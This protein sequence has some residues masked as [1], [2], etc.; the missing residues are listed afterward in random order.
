[1]GYRWILP[2]LALVALLGSSGRTE[3]QP[4]SYFTGNTGHIVISVLPL[5]AQ[6]RLDGVPIGTGHDLTARLLAVFPGP[7]VLEVSA[8][9]YVT[10]VVNFPGYHDWFTSVDVQLVPDRRP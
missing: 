3:A 6:V 8:E 5:T 9:G 1:M 4:V 2:A 7:H 10:S